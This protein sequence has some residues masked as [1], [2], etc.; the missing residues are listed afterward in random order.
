M[1]KLFKIFLFL[2]FLLIIAAA[3]FI[4]TF[5]A[6]NYKAEI[7][8]QVEAATGRDFDIPEK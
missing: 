7:I 5:D 3:G 1:I 2:F 6:N 8:E 4:F